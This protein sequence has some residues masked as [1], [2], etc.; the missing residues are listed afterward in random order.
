MVTQLVKITL[1]GFELYILKFLVIMFVFFFFFKTGDSHL[2][3]KEIFDRDMD[4]L[5]SADGKYSP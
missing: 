5:R 4:W 3:D 1:V 2:T